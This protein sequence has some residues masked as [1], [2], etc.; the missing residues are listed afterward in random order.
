MCQWKV[1]A[2]LFLSD[3]IHSCLE[4]EARDKYE[5]EDKAKEYL[6]N[7]YANSRPIIK[8]VERID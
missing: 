3:H 8:S 5:A 2:D 7:K 4:V 1:V 6:R